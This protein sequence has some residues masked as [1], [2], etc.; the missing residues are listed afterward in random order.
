MADVKT[1][2][3]E[4]QAVLGIEFGSTR[5]KAVLIDPTD[6]KP[7]AQG[8]HEWENRLENGLWTYHL[9][10]IWG[11]LQD[12]Y[13]DLVKDVKNQ[14]GVPLRKLASI[15]FSAMMHGYM[16]FDADGHHLAQFRTWRNANTTKAA[17]ILTDLFQFNIPERWSISHLYQ[18]ILD[19]EDHISKVDFFTTLAG[20]VHWKLT[21]KKVLGIGDASGMFPIDSETK[22]YKTEYMAKFD[23]L[24]KK[25][26]LPYTLK[27]ILP[28]VLEAGEN[29]G[30]LTDEGA[31]L[32]DPT[33]SLE[34]GCP[35]CPPE[36]DAGTGMVA[37]NSVAVRTGNVSAGTSIFAMV[38]LEKALKQLHRE[39]DCV[40]TPDGLQVAMVHANNCTSDLNAWV[41]LFADFLRAADISMD[42][43]TLFK[44]LYNEALKNGAPD[45][46]GIIT[47]GYL[48]G[49]NIT[50]MPEGRPLLARMPTSKFTV[51]NLFRSNLNTSLGAIR[52]GMNILRKE[53]V[54]V[55]KLLGHGGLFKTEGVGQSIMANA[56]DI[57]VWV[58]TTAGEGGAWGI[59]ILAAFVC[60]KKGTSSLPEFL[61][62]CVFK[63]A[64]AT[65]VKPDQEG[66]DGFNKFMERYVL[67][68]GV[69]RQAVE[70]L[71]R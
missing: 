71:K 64:S 13:A 63:D 2:I 45:C 26:S 62:S 38:V 8:S 9:D 18:C 41:G 55:D 15:G 56:L 70:C 69:E 58:M 54:K 49:E 43:T 30:N 52:L 65:E 39:I 11:G 57:P 29:A 42:T 66:V 24:L 19:K 33:G 48:S 4:G 5:I 12:C 46:D 32:L 14:Y 50:S 20:Y 36:G 6:Y 27:Q 25:E 60:D 44:T 31:K 28:K 53:S 35:L 16:A 37:T 22:D 40:T 67:C 3:S 59:A 21:G 51:G 17:Q 61:D 34:S 68:L 23:E 7:I 1:I 47:Y 10:D